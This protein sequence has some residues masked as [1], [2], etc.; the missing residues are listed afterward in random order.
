MADTSTST[1]V[2]IRSGGGGSPLQTPTGKTT[3]ADSVVAKIAG[4]AA[5]EISGVHEM[6]SGA[7]RTFG[8]LREKLPGTAGA[9]GVT[10]GV[11]AEVGERQAAIDLDVVVDY[12]IP[13]VDVS[14]AIRRNV[15]ERIERMTGLEV[16]EVNIFVDDVHLPD[17]PAAPDP[18]RVQ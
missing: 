2:D 18:E 15:I 3:I 9:P 16:T 4:I 17:Q 14:N 11:N 8:A 1:E 12:G 13:I 10:Q 5:R 6:G 7:S